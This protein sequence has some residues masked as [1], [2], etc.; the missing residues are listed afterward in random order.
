M[1]RAKTTPSF[2]VTVARTQK[3]RVRRVHY[4]QQQESRGL[5]VSL[6]LGRPRLDLPLVARTAAECWWA[7]QIPVWEACYQVSAAKRIIAV[8]DATIKDDFE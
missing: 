3:C 1:H 4:A 8:A 5:Q 6:A 7:S 2:E